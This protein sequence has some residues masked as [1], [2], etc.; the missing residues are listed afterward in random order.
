MPR[1]ESWLPVLLL[2]A[3]AAMTLWLNQA[4]QI[5]PAP[6]PSPIRHEPD[7]VVESFSATQFDPTGQVRSVLRAEKM[8]HYPDDGSSRLLSVQFDG[9]EPDQAPFSVRSEEASVSKDRKDVFFYG[10]VRAV[11]ESVSGQ[12]PLVVTTEKL[13]VRPD[14]GIASTDQAVLIEQGTSS[15]IAASLE[16]NNRTRTARLTH[17]KATY[18]TPP[19]RR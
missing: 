4:M 19:K 2:I 5:R 17:V 11:Q 7:A 16:V 6:L 18:N 14:E 12:A 10:N 3:L 8:L 9:R 13:H 1:S 15:T